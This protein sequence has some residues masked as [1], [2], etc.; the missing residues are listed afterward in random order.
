M[1]ASISISRDSSERIRIQIEDDPSGIRVL[2][3][4]M[5]CEEFAKAV[6][7]LSLQN[8][9]VRYGDLQHVGKQKVSEKRSV[10]APGV[11]YVREDARAWLREHGQE[12]GWIVDDYLG[13]QGSIVHDRGGATLNY[14]VYRYVDLPSRRPE[15][16][17]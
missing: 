4:Y 3:V 13:S 12:D 8:I 17:P 6:T 16:A 7:G 2:T 14:R 15:S 9:E 11:G 1:T 5:S 10:V